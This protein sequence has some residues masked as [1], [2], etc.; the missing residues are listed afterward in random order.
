MPVTPELPP[1]W[2]VFDTVTST[3]D[4]VHEAAQ[5]GAPEGTV[6]VA[7][8]QT[9]GRG[10]AGHRWWSPANSGL[11][12]TVLL[13]PKLDVQAAAG[14]ALLVGKAARRALEPLV[15]CPVALYWPNDLYVGPRKLGGILCEMRNSADTYWVAVGIGINI[16][17]DLTDAPPEI[18]NHVIDLDNVGCAEQNPLVLAKHMVDSLFA[19]YRRLQDGDPLSALMTRDLAHVGSRVTVR[20]EAQPDLVGTALGVSDIGEL[21]VRDDRQEIHNVLAGDVEYHER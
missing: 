9:Q 17:V 8:Q 1:Y 19:E 15:D 10:R 18:R 14:L 12:M 16:A 21:L 7:R 4:S 11:W 20:R 6:H 5:A 13:R 2:R 3:N